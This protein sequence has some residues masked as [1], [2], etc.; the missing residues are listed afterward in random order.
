MTAQHALTS[1][2]AACRR[3][4]EA[5]ESSLTTLSSSCSRLTIDLDS[6]QVRE[7][8]ARLRLVAGEHALQAVVA[9]LESLRVVGG[10]GAPGE[11]GG[12][13][14]A[15]N[16]SVLGELLQL[17]RDDAAG[18]CSTFPAPSVDHQHHQLHLLDD[19]RDGDSGTRAIDC[20]SSPPE[21]KRL[22]EEIFRTLRQR[23]LTAH[24][25]TYDEYDLP[26]CSK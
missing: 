26:R 16:V 22:F 17:K 5:S 18:M 14:D 21:Y 9:E 8:D 3:D 6:C 13:Y 4:L 1:K 23:P 10:G 15:D 11:G 19:C 7:R 24:C 25:P 12:A 2:L 20:V